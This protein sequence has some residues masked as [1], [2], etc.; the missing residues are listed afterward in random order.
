MVDAEPSLAREVA[1]SRPYR[2]SGMHPTSVQISFARGRGLHADRG[3]RPRLS[4][5]TPSVDLE[6]RGASCPGKRGPRRYSKPKR[7]RINR[8]DAGAHAY[9]VWVIPI[10]LTCLDA[11]SRGD[12]RTRA[13]V[14]L[15]LFLPNARSKWLSQ[16]QDRWLDILSGS[17]EFRTMD[18]IVRRIVRPIV[19]AAILVAGGFAIARAERCYY[20]PIEICGDDPVA[21]VNCQI[22][23]IEI[24][25]GAPPSTP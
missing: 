9:P 12:I 15:V 21:G 2:Y 18:A 25:I 7:E 6:A 8:R 20:I 13:S 14:P 4:S 3:R 19:L 11:T 5:S 24:C 1:G 10:G 22:V 23:W 17:G 16:M